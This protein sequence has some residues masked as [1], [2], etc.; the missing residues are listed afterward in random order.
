[1]LCPRAAFENRDLLPILSQFL[2]LSMYKFVFLESSF[3][4]IFEQLCA[5]LVQWTKF[6]V[7]MLFFMTQNS[8]GSFYIS[9]CLLMIFVQ[10][11]YSCKAKMTNNVED[12]VIFAKCRNKWCLQKGLSKPQHTKCESVTNNGQTCVNPEIRYGTTSG[13]FLS[14]INPKYNNWMY[15]N[16]SETQAWKFLIS[17]QFV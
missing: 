5:Q 15:I 11:C 12:L 10:K 8:M 9:I 13:Y 7:K 1:M 17:E 2:L 14:P 3:L 6:Y 4:F 16:C